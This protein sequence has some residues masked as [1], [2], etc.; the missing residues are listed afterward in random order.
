MV[1]NTGAEKARSFATRSDKGCRLL[2]ALAVALSALVPRVGQ[3][4]EDDQGPKSPTL[5]RLVVPEDVLTLPSPVIRWKAPGASV[6]TIAVQVVVVASPSEIRAHNLSD[7][8][9]IWSRDLP[10]GYGP[11]WSWTTPLTTVSED[12]VLLLTRDVVSL[13]EVATGTE[14]WSS[15]GP[16]WSVVAAFDSG[17]VLVTRG[18][19]RSDTQT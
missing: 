12:Y 7:G 5:H 16:W 10:P 8:A 14:K 3:A 2:V 6:A 1:M 19:T 17:P 11:L 18:H 4:T 9:M 15:T 13:I